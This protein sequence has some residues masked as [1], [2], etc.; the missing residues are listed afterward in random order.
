MGDTGTV[1]EGG[2]GIDEEPFDRRLLHALFST[3]ALGE[4]SAE[5]AMRAHRRAGG[6]MVDILVRLGLCEEKALAREVAALTGLRLI[7]AADFP[8]A[9]ILRERLSAPFLRDSRVIPIVESDDAVLLA[10]ADPTDETTRR[11]L[12]LV[13]AK[14]L[15]FAVST[16]SEIEDAVLRLYSST[17]SD[18]RDAL[19][20]TNADVTDL[21]VAR[22]RQSAGE[23]P[24]VRF[25]ER[26]IALALDAGASD[27]HIE[28]LE[29]QLRVRM[30]VDGM[31]SD[32]DPA[33]LSS[34]PAIVSRIK[35][36]AR[37]D[38]AERRLPQ[39][40]SIK[41]NVRG[42]EI[43]LRVAT[44]PV[45]HG[46]SVAIRILDRGAIRLDLPLLGF[47][48]RVLG[49][50]LKLL[51]RPNGIVLVTGPTGSGK[52][53]TLYAALDR[54]NTARRKIVTVEDPVEYKIDGLNQIQV[55]PE[56]G[57]DF[58]RTLRSIL[59]HD[60]D[61]I[62]VGE[63]RDG[64]TARIATQ[65][66]L[67][68]HL[69]LSTLHTNDAASAVTRLLDMGIEDYL[70]TSTLTGVLAQRLVRTLCLECRRSAAPADA[71]APIAQARAAAGEEVCVFEAAGCR[72][73]R[74]TGY[75]GRTTIA[76]LM[77]MDG[78]LRSAVL[79]RAEASRLRAAATGSGMQTLY[80]SGLDA[81]FAG[82]TTFEEVLRVAQD[83][84]E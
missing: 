76:E 67:T 4:E 72:S 36:L 21:D 52:S 47:A 18:E 74:G 8:D 46:E 65:A 25:V 31:L 27:I 45:V 43:D 41:T 59:R 24:I 40:G 84:S 29:R 35:I 33:P 37:L 44:A 30:R 13:F 58:A 39:D 11:A 77:I 70:V 79:A 9:A 81:V 17:P 15:T 80:E 38:I 3:G 62:M 2:P 28:P 55:K 1:S 82:R 57:L 23:A 12:G 53:T 48:D 6:S 16:A 10:A 34:G 49:K 26:M 83:V 73:C 19:S 63:I 69:V 68:G 61:A 50:L 5:R 71:L 32:Q 22:L 51:D 20:A 54:L 64:E 75:R 7:A 14:R 66:A 56:I 78:P 42:R 60:P